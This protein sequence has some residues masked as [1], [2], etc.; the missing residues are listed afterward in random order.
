VKR[1]T[2]HPEAEAELRASERFYEQRGG[3][4]LALDFVERVRDGLQLIGAN[5]QR[6]PFLAGCPKVRKCRLARFPFSIYYVE[7]SEDIW[8]LAVA[9]AKRCPG[10]WAERLD[11]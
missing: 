5:P 9:H 1:I 3:P 6:F 4:K 10:Y 11:R 2:L 7:R 8:V